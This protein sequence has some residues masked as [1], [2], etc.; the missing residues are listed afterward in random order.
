MIETPLISSSKRRQHNNQQQNDVNNSCCHDDDDD[1]RTTNS[2]TREK[3]GTATKRRAAMS[4]WLAPL[5]FSAAG[6]HLPVLV[7]VLNVILTFTVIHFQTSSS[8][9]MM[10]I[11]Q[12]LQQG[13]LTLLQQQ[14]EKQQ[15]AA[16]TFQ[17]AVPFGPLGVRG[18]SHVCINVPDVDEAIEFY[19][20]VLG[21]E[22]MDAGELW[23]KFDLRNLHSEEFCKSAGF[24]DGKCRLDCVWMKHPTIHINLELF[25]YYEPQVVNRLKQENWLS[26]THDIGG[27]KHISYAVQ[28]ADR[29]FEFLKGQEGVRFISN[30]PEYRPIRMEPFPFKFFYWIDP[31]GVQWECEEGDEIVTHQIAGVTRIVDKYIEFKEKK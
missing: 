3:R 9:K 16:A 12:E 29:A 15:Q 22:V 19:N 30:D 31:Y 21:Y 23:G 27:L 1:D 14:K 13:E 2:T 28:D 18:I 10:G 8:H 20:R 5:N 7:S 24:M 11:P 6:R 4:C 26:N 25:R 17:D